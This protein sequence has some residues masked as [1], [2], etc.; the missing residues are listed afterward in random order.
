MVND[1]RLWQGKT[2]Q[3]LGE[4]I[5]DQISQATTTIKPVVPSGT[6]SL[7]DCII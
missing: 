2:L 6:C 3:Q 5:P 1:A 4:A 7:R